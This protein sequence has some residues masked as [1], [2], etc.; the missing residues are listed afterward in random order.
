MMDARRIQS[1][2]AAAA[3]AFGLQRLSV[4]KADIRHPMGS[5]QYINK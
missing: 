2:P 1:S 3:A 4:I 5:G